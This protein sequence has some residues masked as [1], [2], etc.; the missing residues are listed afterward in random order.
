MNVAFTCRWCMCLNRLCAYNPPP[1]RV[2]G[3]RVL[4][5]KEQGVSEEQAMYVA[6]VS[7]MCFCLFPLS[8]FIHFQFHWRLKTSVWWGVICRWSTRKRGKQRRRHINS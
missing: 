5:L 1:A 6:D 4:E 8:G 3:L 2:F 7:T